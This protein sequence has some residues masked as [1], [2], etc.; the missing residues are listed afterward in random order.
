VNDADINLSGASHTS[1]DINGRLDVTLSG[2][3]SV[4]YGGDPKLGEFNIT[5][6][7]SLTRR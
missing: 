3:S 6:G 1:L 7:S 4:R 5:G 2:T